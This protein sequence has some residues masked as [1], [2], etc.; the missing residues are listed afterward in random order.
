MVECT[1]NW[2]NNE[3]RIKKDKN[4][5]YAT[6]SLS[7]PFC[8]AAAILCRLFG[9]PDINKFSSEWLPLV[10]AVVNA[11]IMNWA[12]ILSDN[13][14]TAILEYRIKR[15]IASRVYPPFF[16]SAYDMDAI[17]FGSKF[18]IMGW[19][20]SAENPLPIQ[21]YHKVM[22]E[23]NFV[24][25]F[26]KICHGVMLSIHKNIYNR[27]APRFSQE[28]E[29]DILLVAKW[30][31]EELFTY[32]TVFGSI[33]SP[34]VLPFYVLDKLMARDIAYQ[35]CIE[36]GMSKILKYSKNGIWPQ[37]PVTCGVFSLHDLGHAFREV[38]NVLSLQL[39]KFPR[40]KYDPFGIVKY[41]TTMVKIRVF[42]HEKDPFDD[43]F[44]QK[45][46]FKEV[47][48]MA[49]MLFDQEGL[50]TFD[51]Y[52]RKR[53]SKVPLKQLLIEP[54]RDPTLGISISGDSKEKSKTSSEDESTEKSGDQSKITSENEHNKSEESIKDTAQST[55]KFD[56]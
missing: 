30:F 24:P 54:V 1:K 34:H 55:T 46:T 13:L 33:A 11:T 26:F 41:F 32:I 17:C 29:V 7:S 19:K 53:L 49:Q 12:Q 35:K 51:K 6:D 42:T 27:D 31:G 52:R 47:Q 8:Y 23:S 5:M 18:P 48:H 40:R 43:V 22:W 15:S 20:W 10:D 38:D 28:V 45:N 37:F 56:Q 3:E 25:H 16:M 21:I 39:P 4:G 44:L 50:Q 9:K 36:G 14:A 2:S